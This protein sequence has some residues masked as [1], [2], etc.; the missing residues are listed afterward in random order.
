MRTRLLSFVAVLTC[1]AMGT[2]LAAPQVYDADPDHTHIAFEADHFGG[3]SVW[4]GLL[5][6][7]R[8]SVTLDKAAQTGTVDVYTDMSSVEIGQAKLDEE[9]KSPQ[10]FDVAK[11]PEA[12]YQGTLGNFVKGSPTTVTGNLTFHGVTKP[13]SLKILTFRCQQHAFY[14]REV[15][16]ADAIGIF[17]RDEFGVDSGKSYGFNMAVTLRIQI[18]AIVPK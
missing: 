9:L 5:P 15:C 11:Y 2:A 14:K 18:E 10:F 6:K 12:H 7:N 16:G 17:N 1:A 3:L 13:V 4:R 8:G